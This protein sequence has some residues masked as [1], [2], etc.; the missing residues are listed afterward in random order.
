[1]IQQHNPQRFQ[2]RTKRAV[3]V[4]NIRILP[5]ESTRCLDP[6]GVKQRW[7]TGRALECSSSLAYARS[8]SFLISRPNS[9]TFRI[10]RPMGGVGTTAGLSPRWGPLLNRQMRHT[11]NAP[12]RLQTAHGMEKNDRLTSMAAQPRTGMALTRCFA[13]RS[14]YSC[15]STHLSTPAASSTVGCPNA[16]RSQSTPLATAEQASE[17]CCSP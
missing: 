1:M 16:S 7:K 17:P 10:L 4:Q 15:S 2:A 12:Y 11:C 6:G 13:D 5:S 8:R 9:V 14:S 3:K